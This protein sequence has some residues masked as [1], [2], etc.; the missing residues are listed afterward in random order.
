MHD[1]HGPINHGAVSHAIFQ[2]PNR[3]YV[4]WVELQAVEVHRTRSDCVD[5]CGVSACYGATVVKLGIADDLCYLVRCHAEVD[6]CRP[7]WA[8]ASNL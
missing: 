5:G 4:D 3:I 2:Q 1:P 6:D 7:G 8:I